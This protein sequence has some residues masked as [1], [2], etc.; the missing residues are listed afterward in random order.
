MKGAS[1]FTCIKIIDNFTRAAFLFFDRLALWFAIFGLK[2]ENR[3]GAI[4]CYIPRVTVAG[5]LDDL[6]K[7][8]LSRLLAKRIKNYFLVFGI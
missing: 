7:T 6:E 5:W 2:S 8:Q 3:F 4:V 1:I